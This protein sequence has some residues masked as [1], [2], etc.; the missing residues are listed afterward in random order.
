MKSLIK[1]IINCLVLMKPRHT[2]QNTSDI[3]K[4][5]KK[6]DDTAQNFIKFI[7]SK[8]FFCFV[9]KFKLCAL[10]INFLKL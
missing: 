4:V 5:I 3:G 7:S 2:K 1:A 8:G 6:R 9:E 10:L